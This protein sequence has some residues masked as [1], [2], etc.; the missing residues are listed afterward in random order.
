MASADR[1]L[2][3][4]SIALGVIAALLLMLAFLPWNMLRG[5]VASYASHL[6]ERP[7]TIGG[8]LSVDWGRAVVS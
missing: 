6:M 4:G 1:A 5:P 3:Y 7:V 8:D 2:R